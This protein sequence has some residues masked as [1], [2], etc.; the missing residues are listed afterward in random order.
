MCSKSFFP[1]ITLPTRF[2]FRNGTLIDNIFCKTS[3]TT[4]NTPSGILIKTF[5]D[6]HPYISTFKIPNIKEKNMKYVR[7][8]E[9]KD[10]MLINI[11]NDLENIRIIDKLNVGP[12]ANPNINYNTLED[13]LSNTLKNILHSR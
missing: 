7:V 6:H 4:L 9:H 12:F 8:N 1:K 11:S 5:S 10:D 2:S 13:I 3:Y